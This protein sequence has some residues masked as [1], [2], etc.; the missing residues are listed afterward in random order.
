MINLLFLTTSSFTGHLPIVESTIRVLV[1]TSTPIQ[2]TSDVFHSLGMDYNIIRNH[3][4][5]WNFSSIAKA[6]S[7]SY[8]RMSGTDADRM[9]FSVKPISD[10]NPEG[11]RYRAADWP[12][13]TSNFKM[14]AWDWDEI[15]EFA[16]E[17]RRRL[18]FGL[19]AQLRNGT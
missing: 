1:H 13:P 17:V 15:N 5:T 6:L 19:D 9:L 10:L 14:S 4:D 8:L 12:F 18:L 16:D 3:W 2:V 7:P 11:S